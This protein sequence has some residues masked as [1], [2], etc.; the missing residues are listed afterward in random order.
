MTRLARPSPLSFSRCCAPTRLALPAKSAELSKSNSRAPTATPTWCRPPRTWRL[1]PL[2]APITRRTAPSSSSKPCRPVPRAVSTVPCSSPD[3]G[4][5]LKTQ[6]PSQ[7]SLFVASARGRAKP[8]KATPRPYTR[9]IL[10]IDS[11][12][13]SHTKATPR[14]HQGYTKATPR[15]HQGYTKAT[16]K[17][18]QGYTN[19]TPRLHQGYTKATPRPHQSHPYATFKPPTSVFNTGG[20]QTVNHLLG[21]RLGAES[22]R[23]DCYSARF[24]LLGQI[25][26]A[27]C[28]ERV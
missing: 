3:P 7:P 10:G 8:P 20:I 23:K 2:S 19:A 15:L 6:C 22:V 25:G 24:C 18:H 17:L 5:W 16:P 4:V 26:R 21:R 11:G 9:H 12:V 27:S 13:Q 14:L 28:R 1:G